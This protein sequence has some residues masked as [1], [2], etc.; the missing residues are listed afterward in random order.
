[1]GRAA[2]SHFIVTRGDVP[3][4]LLEHPHWATKG[5]LVAARGSEPTK[6]LCNRT[7]LA[8]YATIYARRQATRAIKRTL[9]FIAA[10]EHTLADA[11]EFV[12]LVRAGPSTWKI[13]PV[14]CPTKQNTSK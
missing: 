10:T 3:C 14:K 8:N 11:H 4:V 12:A 1:M 2:F 13:V 6:F 7:T 5:V 9:E